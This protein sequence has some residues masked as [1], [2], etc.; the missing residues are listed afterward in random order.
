[1]ILVGT[2]FWKGLLDWVRST[3]LPMGLIGEKDLDL[4][5]VIDDP[6]DILKAVFAFYD[7]HI[8]PETETSEKMFYL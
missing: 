5:Q 1:M 4:V 3:M 7:G 2:E 8:E 6:D